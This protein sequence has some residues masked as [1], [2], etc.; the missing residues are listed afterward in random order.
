MHS[1]RMRIVR[2]SDHGGGAGCLPDWGGCL[3]GG[4]GCLSRRGVWPGG[5]CPGSV[6]L[7][8]V[9]PGGVSPGGCLP[10]E[11]LPQCMLGYTPL[12][13][14]FCTHTCEN[15]T[16]PQLRL[17]TVTKWKWIR[18]IF[19]SGHPKLKMSPT[20]LH[21]A[22]QVVNKGCMKWS[23]LIKVTQSFFSMLTYI[24]YVFA[25]SAW[26]RQV[27]QVTTN[28]HDKMS[29]QNIITNCHNKLSQTN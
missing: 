9:C 26:I 18:I 29:L 19:L 12:W 4:G 5:V 23:Y 13:T 27:I 28:R 24:M 25:R 2:C 6:C 1:S 3:P 7:G 21:C 22:G 20:L 15:I 16:F 11:G 17:R 8:C 14:E 10:R